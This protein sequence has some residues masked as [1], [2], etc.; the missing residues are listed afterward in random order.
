MQFD[1]LIEDTLL[2]ILDHLITHYTK[3]I[4]DSSI[5]HKVINVGTMPHIEREIKF[6]FCH[7][8]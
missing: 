6:Y 4:D 1:N 3:V 5:V 2:E 7:K 8:R